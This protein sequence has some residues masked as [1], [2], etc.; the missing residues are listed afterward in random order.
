MRLLIILLILSTDPAKHLEDLSKF[1][2][3]LGAADYNPMSNIPGFNKGDQEQAMCMLFRSADISH[4]AKDWNIHVEWSKRVT[5]EFHDQG[6][7][8]KRL[9][10]AV[11]PLCDREGFVL[12]SS[13]V[14]FLQF[15]CVP[16]WKELARFEEIVLYLASDGTVS[17]EPP[18]PRR[19]SVRLT[20]RG[21]QNSASRSSKRA[22]TAGHLSPGLCTPVESPRRR[23]PSK[24]S[25]DSPVR[26]RP[27]PCHLGAP[28]P[29]CKATPLGPV[30]MTRISSDIGGQRSRRAS[31][32]PA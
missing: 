23:R 9:G 30:Q 8:E 31:P 6:D 13:Q 17:A 15:I 18:L 19:G 3:R 5:M 1:R 27:S 14:G 20:T 28:Q 32:W 10:L 29:E 11:S 21:S 4:S 24:V 26:R 2:V 12:A 25:G 7:E 22:Q 16:T